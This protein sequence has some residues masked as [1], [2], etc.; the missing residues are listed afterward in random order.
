MT[1]IIGLFSFF[2]LLVAFLIWRK[3]PR[4]QVLEI[5][6]ISGCIYVVGFLVAMPIVKLLSVPWLDEDGIGPYVVP[7]LPVLAF[8][9]RALHKLNVQKNWVWTAGPKK[10]GNKRGLG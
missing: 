7:L 4:S 8:V 2:A 6:V 1:V 5:F 10:Y 9:A 3:V